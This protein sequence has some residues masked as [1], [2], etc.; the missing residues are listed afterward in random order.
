VSA[1][2]YRYAFPGYK[3]QKDRAMFLINFFQ[4]WNMEEGI[5]YAL[6]RRLAKHPIVNLWDMLNTAIDLRSESVSF[7]FPNP[8]RYR[9]SLQITLHDE[10]QYY[11][12]FVMLRQCEFFH[13]KD[14]PSGMEY[15]TS[16]F[17]HSFLHSLH[18]IL[19]SSDY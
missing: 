7:A 1:P 9:A 15:H 8:W 13:I 3:T 12:G 14:I 19:L 11:C 18:S 10:M 6:Y 4:L 17:L 5:P 2:L 16:S